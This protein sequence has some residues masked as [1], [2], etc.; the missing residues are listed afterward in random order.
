M[1]AADYRLMTEATGQRIAA[2]L[3]ALVNLGDPV[4]IAH[5]GTGANTA[6]G[7][8]AALGGVAVTDIVN[9]LTST[10]TDK[11]GSANML[12]T[13][14]DKIAKSA[15]VN[16]SLTGVKCRTCGALVQVYFNVVVTLTTTYQTIAT[17]PSAEYCPDVNVYALCIGSLGDGIVHVLINMNGNIQAK[18]DSGTGAAI[19]GIIIY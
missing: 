13:L 2:A 12:K 15:W 10:E 14:N 16:T 17:L 3:E 18:V 5:G 6:A 11:P 7:A 4:T 9:N 8:L 1:A 19:N